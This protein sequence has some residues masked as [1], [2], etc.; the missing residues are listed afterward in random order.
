[1]KQICEPLDEMADLYDKWHHRDVKPTNIIVS[2]DPGRGCVLIDFG[3]AKQLDTGEDREQVTGTVAPLVSSRAREREDRPIHRCLRPW[4]NHALF[5]QSKSGQTE[6]NPREDKVLLDLIS[7]GYPEKFSKAA[8]ATI[9]KSLKV[10]HQE[11]ISTIDEFIQELERLSK[12][13]G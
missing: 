7:R 8:A 9:A 13:A 2:R 3:L 12:L 5:V 10:P 4:E 6:L 1:M 11:R